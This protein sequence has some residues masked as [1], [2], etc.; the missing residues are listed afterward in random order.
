MSQ[1]VW[2]ESAKERCEFFFMVNLT[3]DAYRYF[4][5]TVDQTHSYCVHPSSEEV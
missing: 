3:T 5:C 2:G 4:L 1:Q